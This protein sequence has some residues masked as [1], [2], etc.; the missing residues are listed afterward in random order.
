MMTTGVTTKTIVIDSRDA[1]PSSSSP[2]AYTVLLPEALYDITAA[3]LMSAEIPASFYVFSTDRGNVTFSLVRNGTP[4]TVTIPE[5]NYGLTAMLDTLSSVLTA[6]CGVPIAV[7]APKNTLRCTISSS[8]PTD[9]LGVDTR[10]PSSVASTNWGLAYYLGFDRDVLL[11]IGDHTVRAPRICMMNPELSMYVD[12][13][14]LGTM[15]ESRTEGQGGTVSRRA[16]AKIPFNADSFQYVYFDKQL[17]S[18]AYTPPIAT[19]TKLRVSWR[20]HTGEPVDFHGVHHSLTL[21][22]ECAAASRRPNR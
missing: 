17:S 14:E 4:H 5:G 15:L 2:T 8:V 20:F 21:Q 12:I 6:A 3:R 1:A 18:H 22:L 11:T 9:V 19:L 16:F 10:S 13:E 7:T